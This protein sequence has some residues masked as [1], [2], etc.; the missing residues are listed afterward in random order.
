MPKQAGASRDEWL[1]SAA[2][3][4]FRRESQK[5]FI[6]DWKRNELI[7]KGVKTL[8]KDYDKLNRQR[9]KFVNQVRQYSDIENKF[10]EIGKLSEYEQY[11]RLAGEAEARLTQARMNMNMDERLASYP[12]DML[13]VPMDQLI[14]RGLLK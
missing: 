9:N 12:Y 1:R 8:K 6:P 14:V 10:S 3:Y 13:D 2:A 7:E 4:M 11:R 5:S